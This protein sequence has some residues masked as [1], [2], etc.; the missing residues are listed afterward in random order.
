MYLWQTTSIGWNKLWPKTRQ[1]NTTKTKFVS[2]R[3]APNLS[4]FISA[5]RVYNK[6]NRST[7][8]LHDLLL[9]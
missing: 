2:L 3:N 1:P 5:I 8:D 7:D 6:Y 9:A 4:K